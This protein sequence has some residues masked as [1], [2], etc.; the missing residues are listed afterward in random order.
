[1]NFYPQQLFHIYNQG[2]NRQQVFFT[3]E[4]YEFFLWKMRAHL[5]P[6]GELVA[7]CLMPNHFHW[8][9]N[10]QQVALERKHYRAW[11]DETELLRRRKKFG[12]AAQPVEPD[13]RPARE[14]STITRWRTPCRPIEKRYCS[15]RALLV[16]GLWLRPLAA[17]CYPILYIPAV[18]TYP[19]RWH[20]VCP[21]K[22]LTCNE[23][24]M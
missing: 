8:L 17:E 13:K 16:D 10:V 22:R 6:F 21:L 23:L 5:L 7:W 19:P 4:H 20:R 15:S 11:V 9:F 2:N 14:D 3:A 12:E 18:G 24:Y 1:M